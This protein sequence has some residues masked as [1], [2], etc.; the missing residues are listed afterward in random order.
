[1]DKGAHFLLSDNILY[2]VLT[3]EEDCVGGVSVLQHLPCCQH[4]PVVFEYVFSG[5]GRGCLGRGERRLRRRGKYT[6]IL[7]ALSQID[8]GLE[9]SYSSVCDNFLFLRSVLMSL[10]DNYVPLIPVSSGPPWAVRVPP[11]LAQE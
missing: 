2:L 8:W 11:A 5:E 10:I 4:S 3:S 6:R 1:M 9:F 7:E